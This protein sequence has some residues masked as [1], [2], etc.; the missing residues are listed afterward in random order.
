MLCSSNVVVFL[1]GSLSSAID[2]Y[3]QVSDNKLERQTAEP[4]NGLHVP[5]I[6][7]AYASEGL[8]S[9]FL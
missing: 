1:C 4:D 2:F 7:D 8:D 6:V 3:R 9:V 5:P